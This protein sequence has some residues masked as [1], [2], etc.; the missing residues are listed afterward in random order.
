MLFCQQRLFKNKASYMFFILALAK[1]AY[2]SAVQNKKPS[3]LSTTELTAS[4]AL[5]Q[6]YKL[7]AL[8]KQVTTGNKI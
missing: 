2:M 5:I 8:S 1:Q 3:I 7:C 4:E 6:Y